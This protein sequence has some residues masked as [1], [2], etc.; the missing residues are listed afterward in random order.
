MPPD[1]HIRALQ[2]ADVERV[3]A[4]V[5]RLSPQARRDRYFSAI[6]ELAPRQLA[7][8]TRG[9]DRHHL[10][11]GAFQGEM[12]VALAEYAGG[13]FGVVVADAWQGSGLGRALMQRLLAHA[14]RHSEPALHGLVR[15]SNRAMLHLAASLGFHAQRD[16]DPELLRVHLPRSSSG[17]RRAPCV[18]S[19]T[20]QRHRETALP[21]AVPKLPSFS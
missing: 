19:A 11:L 6:R 16:A 1:V 7:R 14:E 3:Q 12:L 5:G 18:T 17:L 9:T 8:M 2:E 4:F 20:A 10:N 13:E 21:R 15:E